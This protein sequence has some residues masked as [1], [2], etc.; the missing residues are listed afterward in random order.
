MS[1]EELDALM[2]DAKDAE[3][4]ELTIDLEKQEIRRPNGPVIKF[5]FDEFRRHC[6]LNGLDDI[7]LTLQKD[8][9]ISDFESA[10]KSS[11]GLK[12]ARAS[13][14]QRDASS[15]TK[16][17]AGSTAVMSANKK[18]LVLPGDGIG[19]EAEQVVRVVDWFGANRAVG[20]DVKQDPGRRRRL[21]CTWHATLTDDTLAA[22]MDA[23]AVLF[24]S[25]DGP[26]YDDAER[27]AARSRSPEIAQG[28]GTLRKSSPGAHLR[29]AAGMRLL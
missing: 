16:E 2:A 20:F 22:A 12:R 13:N 26:K 19:P 1:R 5:D 3:N 18:L 6:L 14:G 23:D 4:P 24:G 10:S 17:F 7:G 21:R 28:N 29:R 27:Q 9:A 8:D 11:I 15:Q 25:I